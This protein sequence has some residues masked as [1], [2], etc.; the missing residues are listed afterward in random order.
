MQ[1]CIKKNIRTPVYLRLR[2]R[3]NHLI[4][5]MRQM[6]WSDNL[7]INRKKIQ[8]ANTIYNL[9]WKLRYRFIE[10]NRKVIFW[11]F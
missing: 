3:F 11:Y 10:V 8:K 4:F 1:K 6:D 5:T 7:R 9:L 2:E